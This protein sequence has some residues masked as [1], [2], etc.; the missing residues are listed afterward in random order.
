MNH[1][2]CAVRIFPTE[3]I[4]VH[5]DEAGC[6]PHLVGEVTAGLHPL[7]IEAHIVAGRIS[8][9]QRETQCIRAVLINHLQRVNT[10]S[11]GLTHLA[12]L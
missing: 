10:I 2:L 3:R 6:I 8:G 1:T 7:P 5:H 12:S 9:D 4:Q 11:Q